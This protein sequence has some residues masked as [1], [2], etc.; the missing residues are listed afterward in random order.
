MLRTLTVVTLLMCSTLA[1]ADN[2]GVGAYAS[3]EI[4]EAQQQV[5]DYR[6]LRRACSITQGE[7]RRLCF[8]RLSDATDTYTKAKTILKS[9]EASSPL[10]GQVEFDQ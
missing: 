4:K 10:L 7:Q 1:F 5:D 2:Y 8:S 6:A 3:Y 9:Q